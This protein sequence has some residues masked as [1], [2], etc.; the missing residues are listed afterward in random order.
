MEAGNLYSNALCILLSHDK[1]INI[2]KMSIG[3]FE[4]GRFF[5][6]DWR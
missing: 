3:I 5:Q 2:I 1:I 4:S 6:F